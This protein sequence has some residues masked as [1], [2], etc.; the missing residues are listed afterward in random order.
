M[1]FLTSRKHSEKINISF[2]I[3]YEEV[4]WKAGWIPKTVYKYRD[5]GNLNHKGIIGQP[6]I[7]VPDSFDFNDPFDCNI[8]VAY[9]LIAKDDK[10]AKQF[11]RTIVTAK[12]KAMGGDVEKEVE[13]RFAE[14]RHKDKE[15][16]ESYKKSVH[17][18][19]RKRHGVFS[20][21]PINNNILMWS[22]Y[23][24]CHKGFCVGFDSV[25]LFDY[26]GGGGSVSYA[27]E[28]P[29]IS[30]IE[31]REEQY[32]R[33]VLTKSVHWA[34]EIEYRLTTFNKVNTCIDFP[35][36]VITEIIFGSK[37]SEKHKGEILELAHKNLPHVKC[38]SAIPD[39]SNFNLRI[40][41]E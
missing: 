28:Y 22:H 1:I 10:I 30:P 20:V 34:Y 23:A 3:E 40:V 16:L 4:E 7:W 33:Q 38:F 21:T 35:A 14:G 36:N 37:I 17:L 6:Q 11:I 8:P 27:S 26:L 25:K 31:T 13:E 39:E 24:N 19:G 12:V 18:E 15:F 9:D 5:W 41:P 2:D 29:I 32:R